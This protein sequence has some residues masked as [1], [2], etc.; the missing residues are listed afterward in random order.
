EIFASSEN[1]TNGPKL[2]MV[3]STGIGTTTRLKV[4]PY[5]LIGS[6][7]SLPTVDVTML[8]TVTGNRTNLTVTPPAILTVS[9]SAGASA[10]LQAGYP[11]PASVILPVGG[12]VA[13]FTY[14]YNITGLGTT[15]GSLS[16]SGK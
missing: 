2:V 13:I 14:K 16:F 3:Y 6:Q 4:S 15:P 10:V 8:V 11:S 1:V 12:G 9:A 5:R 7:S